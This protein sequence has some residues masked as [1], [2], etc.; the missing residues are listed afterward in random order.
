MIILYRISFRREKL[1]KLTLKRRPQPGIFGIFQ[2]LLKQGQYRCNIRLAL[3]ILPQQVCNLFYHLLQ[4]LLLFLF[5][6]GSHLPSS[7]LNNFNY[8]I[9]INVAHCRPRCY[10]FVTYWLVHQQ[11]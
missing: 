1:A 11:P 7:I 3:A 5:S 4:Q 6:A 2:Y 9:E 8:H 10:G